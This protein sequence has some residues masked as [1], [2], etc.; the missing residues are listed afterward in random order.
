MRI[1]T[2]VIALV[3]MLVVGVQ[4]CMV[5]G[6]GS[7]GQDEDLAGGGAIGVLVG[8]LFL[9]GGAFSFARPK[10]SMV[11]FGIAA[12]FGFIGS[13]T[14]FSD[15]SVYAWASLILACMSYFGDKELRKKQ[16]QIQA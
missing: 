10:I 13:T 6:L 7:L 3:I 4:S 1:A 14:G 9:L 11:V 8:F 2:G 12:L 5:T 16:E 15:L